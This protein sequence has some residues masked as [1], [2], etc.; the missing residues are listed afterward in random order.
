MTEKTPHPNHLTDIVFILDRSGSMG[1]REFDTIEGYNT[2]LAKQKAE[3][4]QARVT[5]ILFDDRTDVIHQRQD[6]QSV[7]SLTS[8]EY[9]VRGSTALLDAI[10]KGIHHL[11][12]AH[13]LEGR[14]KET[15]GAIF[16]I[17]TDGMENASHETSYAQLRELIH[18]QTS[19]EGWEFIYLGADLSQGEDAD[20][21]GIARDRQANYQKAQ[22]MEAFDSV[23]DSIRS[24]RQSKSIANNWRDK[25]AQMDELRELIQKLPVVQLPEGRFLIA[26]DLKTSIGDMNSV[27]VLEKTYPLIGHPLLQRTRQFSGLPIDG[28]IGQDILSQVKVVFKRDH[29]ALQTFFHDPQDDL[30]VKLSQSMKT[31]FVPIQWIDGHPGMMATIHG[32]RHKFLFDTTAQ[33]TTLRE[34]FREEPVRMVVRDYHVKLGLIQAPLIELDLKITL[35][36]GTLDQ[37]LIASV[38]PDIA[39]EGLESFVG[40][41]SLESFHQADVCVLDLSKMTL[42]LFK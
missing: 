39:Y 14:T 36:K 19:D 15:T 18:H 7:H 12:A 25:F 13:A 33:M 1:G 16:V 37:N 27:T 35:D 22:T 29:H 5:T 28:M 24:Y 17:I 34:G 23:S 8:S 3:P 42:S 20:R 31:R 10:A 41:L 6:I 11:K 38:L 40:S 21:M 32:R 2:F 30:E 26:T 4:G 9:Y